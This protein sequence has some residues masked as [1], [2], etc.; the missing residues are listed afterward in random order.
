[1]RL[2][3]WVGFCDCCWR[4]WFGGFWN[5]DLS[6]HFVDGKTGQKADFKLNQIQKKRGI[7]LK[8]RMVFKKK[9][10]IENKVG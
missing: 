7:E 3:N 10:R 4:N 8:F 5:W 6:R 2:G 9:E 1:M